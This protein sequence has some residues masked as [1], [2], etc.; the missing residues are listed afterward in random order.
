MYFMSGR[1]ADIRNIGQLSSVN[2]SLIAL[3]HCHQCMQTIHSHFSTDYI[4]PLTLLQKLSP[5]TMNAKIKEL[6][7]LFVE[8]GALVG[9][10]TGLAQVC[11][12]LLHTS[13]TK[14]THMP[15][16]ASVLL[17]THICLSPHLFHVSRIQSCPTL[18]TCKKKFTLKM[19]AEISHK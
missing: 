14:H 5:L 16:S 8:T 2:H 13:P 15:E 11:V 9:S 3:S 4:I 6:L 17:A 19:L 18:E 1:F 12:V 10:S 7:R